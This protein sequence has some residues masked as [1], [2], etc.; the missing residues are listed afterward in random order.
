LFHPS[1]TQRL[2]RL[3]VG[4]DIHVVQRHDGSA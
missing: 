3:R 2:L 1:V 4:A